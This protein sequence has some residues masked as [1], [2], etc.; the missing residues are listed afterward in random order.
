MENS[1]RIAEPVALARPR[2]AHRFEA[3]SPKL[4]RRLTFY[5]RA[6]VEQWVLLEADPAVITFCERPGYV[7]IDRQQRLAD[8]WVRYVGRQELVILDDSRVDEKIAQSHRDLD[9]AALPIRRVGQAEL[10]AARVWIDNWQRMLP[11]IVANLSLVSP[12]VSRAIERFL[13]HPQ[14]LLSIER[15]FSTRDPVL[16][17]TALFGLLHAGRVSAPDLH[18]QALSLLT[19]FVA[20]QANS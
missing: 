3:F 14:R 15:E 6:L 7:N 9:A 4:A 8:F 11:C 18:T 20:A 13:D 16:V 5:R 12:S 1:L 17:R 19:S 10:A 2:G